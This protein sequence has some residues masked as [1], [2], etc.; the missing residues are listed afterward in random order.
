MAW[1]TPKTWTTGELVTAA[2]LNTHIRDNLDALFSPNSDLVSI[3]T[4]ITTTSGTFVDATGLVIIF[5]IQGD[6]ALIGF[7]GVISNSSAAATLTTVE[8]DVDG[9]DVGGSE[10]L[11]QVNQKGQANGE[12]NASFTWRITGLSA[13]S[14]TFKIE[15]KTS[16][17]TATLHATNSE[18]I[19]WGAEIT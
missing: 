15:W 3:T 4:D 18:T 19:L 12:S 7:T 9:V 14:H 11:I 5:T 6:T 2:Q 1:T 17:G 10:G 13:A 8:L 16:A